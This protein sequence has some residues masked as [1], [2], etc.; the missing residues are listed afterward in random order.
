M[1]NKMKAVA[2]T[3][4]RQVQLIEM[5][6]PQPGPNEIQIRIK[7]CALCT[8]EQ[9][10][11]TGIKK[12]PLPLIGGHEIAGE[13]SAVG[14]DVTPEQYPVGK[15]VAGRIVK[16]CHSCY[17]C[18]RGEP[19]QC[20]ELNTFRLNG[21]DFY[22]ME[23]LGE[24][25]CLDRSAVWQ[26]DSDLSFEEISLTEP[27]ACVLRSIS[28]AR[29]NIGDDAVVIGGGIMGQLHLRCL[30]KLGVRT[31]LSEPDES[32]RS[33]A[34]MNGCSVALDPA[35]EDVV[36]RVKELTHGRGAESVFNTT[37]ISQVETDAIKMTGHLGCCITYSSQHPDIPVEV[38]PNWLHNSEA[39]LTGAVNP[40]IFSFEQAVN[41]LDKGILDVKDLISAVFP[42]ENAHEAF[43]KALSLDTYRVIINM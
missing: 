18:R 38:S 24:Y 2:I 22:G 17:Y 25:I 42:K 29:P 39:S 21:P 31:I 20:V 32:R 16:A 41:V 4:E 14:S 43:E 5:D 10:V 15:R 30:Q 11:F 3:G 35:N 33:F 28:R 27:V 8:W 12:A 13:I 37:A 36:Q 26:F 7:A 23:G 9:R 34:L 19:T 40:S 1:A 6:R